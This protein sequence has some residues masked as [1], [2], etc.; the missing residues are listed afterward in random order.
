MA[1]KTNIV[2]E[3][4]NNEKGT[5]LQAVKAVAVLVVICLVCCLLLALCNDLLYVTEEEKFNRAMRK[6]YPDFTLDQEVALDSK[7][8]SNATYG[9]V[10]S[11][12]KSTDGAY[13]LQTKGVGGFNSGTITIYVAVT[14]G[15]NP[16][17]AGWTVVANEGQS[18]IGNIT[19]NHQK[20]WFIGDSISEVQSVSVGNGFGSGATYSEMAICNAINMAGYYC[21]NALGLGSNPEGEAL[22][23]V[24]D[25]LGA[26]YASYTLTG[27]GNVLSA[28]AGSGTVATLLST[29]TDTLSYLFTGTGDKG[30]VQ[31]FVYGEGDGIKI[32]VVT[33]SGIVTSENVADGDAALLAVQSKPLYTTTLGSYTAFALTTSVEAGADSTVY[34]VAGLGIGTVPSTYVLKVTV[35]NDSG[36]GKVSAIEIA[37]NGYV[38]EAPS[39]ADT[40]KL[41]TSLVGAT[42][43]TVDGIYTSDHVAGATQSANLITVAVKAALAQFD[44]TVAAE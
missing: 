36:A 9:E 22:Q 3:V 41:A 21:M 25:L 31:A 32:I 15:E 18:F 43:A 19:S 11:V 17:I 13:I 23:A 28:N 38:P 39:Q 42:S 44:A 40:D 2:K 33:D 20:T 5:A 14:G 12:V 26:D 4:N 10:L 27:R 34:T 35:T 16:T 37:T 30:D 8:S 24:M 6:I 29:D 1:E 7:Y